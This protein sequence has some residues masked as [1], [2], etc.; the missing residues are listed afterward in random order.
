MR[1]R[2]TRVQPSTLACLLDNG[3][4]TV[5]VAVEF[6]GSGDP[7]VDIIFRISPL[8]LCGDVG[9]QIADAVIDD[10]YV[11]GGAPVT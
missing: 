7:A 2:P 11:V 1:D 9:E 3:P 5:D 4:C 6:I 10:V 8:Q